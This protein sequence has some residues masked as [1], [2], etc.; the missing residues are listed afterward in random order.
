MS[1]L[2][3][4]RAPA[5]DAATLG[6]VQEVLRE[7]VRTESIELA[8]ANP[9][10]LSMPWHEQLRKAGRT[11]ETKTVLQWLEHVEVQ[12]RSKPWPLGTGP[13]DSLFARVRQGELAQA[14]ALA[15]AA[16]PGLGWRLSAHYVERMCGIAEHW[17][18]S[19]QWA[20]GVLLAKL[21]LAAVDARRERLGFEQ[22]AMEFAATV[23]WLDVVTRATCD[24]PDPRLFHDAVARGKKL[25]GVVDDPNGVCQPAAILHGLG[26][27]H[28]DPYVGGR[29][30]ESY[31]LQH[32][33]WL[34]RF[35]VALAAENTLLD[36]RQP[37]MPEPLDALSQAADYLAHAARHRSGESLGRTRK[38]QLQAL[39]W[40]RHLGGASAPADV[41]RVAA[42]AL[43]ALAGPGPQGLRTDVENMLAWYRRMQGGATDESPGTAL[44]EE[45]RSLLAAPVDEG[46]QGVAAEERLARYTQ[47]AT[48]IAHVAPREAFELWSRVQALGRRRAPEARSQFFLQGLSLLQHA[49]APRALPAAPEA[50]QAE[51]VHLQSGA[52]PDDA[53]RA[54][55][56]LALALHSGARNQEE[57]ALPIVEAAAEASE[58][59]ASR[60]PELLQ[61]ARANLLL[62]AAVNRYD[63]QSY[64]AAAS[65]YM[66][67]AAAFLDCGNATRAMDAVER[68][69]DIGRRSEPGALNWFMAG[70]TGIAAR[71][72]DSSDGAAEH[73]QRL[74]R[75]VLALLV[76]TG[77]LKLVLFLLF[78]NLAK[79]H[80][81]AQALLEGGPREWLASP[82]AREME[83]RIAALAKECGPQG[84]A[85]P[86]AHDFGMVLTSYASPQE[87]AGGATPAERL[88]NLR[89]AF[90]HALA[91]AERGHA[92][93]R[94]WITTEDTVQ[95]ALG[96][97]SAL[98]SL[99]FGQ[100]ADGDAA[101]FLLLLTRE[102]QHFAVGRLA[103]WNSNLL[104]MESGEQRITSSPFALAV[105]SLHEAI[106]Q[107][108]LTRDVSAAAAAKLRTA[109]DTLLGGG[110][111]EQLQALRAAGK[112]HLYVWP[113]GPYHF[114]PFHL[115][116]SEDAPLA[117]DWTVTYLANLHLLDPARRHAAPLADFIAIGL[118]FPPDNGRGLAPLVDAE[119]E[120]LEVTRVMEAP[121]VLT[122]T[123]LGKRAVLDALQSHRRLHIATHG[124]L[125]VNT[126]AFQALYLGT[127]VGSEV[128]HAYEIQRLDLR[129]VDLVTLSACDT[130]LGRFDAADNLRG[131]PASLLTAG[132]S[133]IVG[134]LWP[135]ETTCS[136]HFF[137]QLYAA[138][139]AG[140]AKGEAFRR[141]Q[142]QSRRRFPQHRDWGA[143]YLNGEID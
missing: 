109:Q 120:A 43:R 51:C 34:N 29:S 143:F 136:R 17:A 133:T 65:L 54:A 122:G 37:K 2:R 52:E 90:E 8:F 112:D 130:A 88:R 77:E 72:E 66:R 110:M 87:Q 38:A 91:H 93:L 22:A 131:F 80:A 140:A 28:L 75:E 6:Q 132:V 125:P 116:G 55:K 124:E 106:Q 123:A 96:P 58:A 12:L 13:L 3:L 76:N 121:R 23:H 71:L 57:D 64:D 27:L 105:A 19:G 33:V 79:G 117:Q 30:N 139:H 73:L 92:P 35:R 126:P 10:L 127:D 84:E 86:A 42:N 53:L 60:H 142:Q 50:L 114:A 49:F 24:V 18:R 108:P 78:L 95:Q 59:F 46:L 98:L 67:S 100:L 14:Q 11:K 119:A 111:W 128:L 36:D 107:D 25:A 83:A 61:E 40:S 44:L 45:V 16:A 118:D 48:A 15:M 47:T 113:H 137:T 56:L 81:F 41:E 32:A 20:D 82:P 94:Q 97:R 101:V 134:T 74:Y 68:V 31:Q 26:V 7:L 39:V 138:L 141:A 115:F 63:A 62:G 70:M 9:V 89:I 129:G 5:V 104:V 103:G 135:V 69:V 21:V 102:E 4:G 85:A 1:W 99:Y